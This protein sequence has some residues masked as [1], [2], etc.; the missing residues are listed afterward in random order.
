MGSPVI[1]RL[2]AF[3]KENGCS[4]VDLSETDLMAQTSVLCQECYDR[5]PD[6][7]GKAHMALGYLT[8]GRGPVPD[9]GDETLKRGGAPACY[10]EGVKFLPKARAEGAEGAGQVTDNLLIPEFEFIQHSCGLAPRFRRLRSRT[11]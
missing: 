9:A 7:D 2:E 5:V 3:I 11:A 10:V 8:G 1:Q 6:E 4:E